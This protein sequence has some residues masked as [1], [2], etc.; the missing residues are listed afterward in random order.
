MNPE[1]SSPYGGIS[2]RR[3]MNPQY[4]SPN[5]V[6]YLPY[7]W[8]HMYFLFW[9]PERNNFP[10]APPFSFSQ[11]EVAGLSFLKS[12][13]QGRSFAPLVFNLPQSF[14]IVLVISEK[15]EITIFCFLSIKHWL[16]GCRSN[17]DYNL[18]EPC[19]AVRHRTTQKL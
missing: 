4:F 7:P 11:I 10:R 15:W 3:H 17:L 13:S 5:V 19:L 18:P 1:P 12:K 9:V 6:F 8:P 16:A 2:W 14:S